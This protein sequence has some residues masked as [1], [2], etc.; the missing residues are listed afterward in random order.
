M[1]QS[2]DLLLLAAGGVPGWLVPPLFVLGLV[3]ISFFTS[4]KGGWFGL[5]KRF[6]TREPRPDLFV[7]MS[8]GRMGWTHYNRCLTVGAS[9]AGLYLAMMPSFTPFHPPLL[10]P[11]SE[12]KERRR[13]TS[14]FLRV[15]TLVIGPDR[16]VVRIEALVMDGLA[17]YAR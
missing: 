16:T 8:S 10:I 9:E 11:W 2:Q 12:I 3:A 14:Q 4:V 6:R 13:E 17:R 15:E 1:L 5:A 7:K